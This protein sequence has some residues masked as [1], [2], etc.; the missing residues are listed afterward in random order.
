M[1]IYLNIAILAATVVILVIAFRKFKQLG[2]LQC[3][4]KVQIENN[5]KLVS[6]I[7]SILETQKKILEIRNERA[8]AKKKTPNSGDSA[9]RVTRLNGLSES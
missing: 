5:T 7:D 2:E 3:Q 8:P 9:T 1:S 4:L 6:Q